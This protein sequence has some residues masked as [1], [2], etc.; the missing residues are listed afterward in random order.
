MKI[1]IAPNAF[2][3]SLSASSAAAIL[4][5]VARKQ[6]PDAEILA[7]PIADG[8][9]GLL[10]ALAAQGGGQWQ[11]AQVADPLGRPVEASLLWFPQRRLACIESAEAIG[12]RLLRDASPDPM[13]ASS[14][15]LGQLILAALELGAHELLI[16][17]G[18][19]ATNDGGLGLAQALGCRLLDAEGGLLAGNGQGL[20][21]FA[22]LD[23]NGLN[24]R[25]AQL[26][27]SILAD[28]ANPLLGPEGATA[29]YGPQKGVGPETQM[30][31]EAG[32][33]RLASRFFGEAL[34]NQPGVGAAGGL[35]AMLRALLG[36]ELVAGSAQVLDLL[37]FDQALAGSRL[38]LTS[39]G[40]LD[41]Q[42]LNG[43]APA[44]VAVR[45]RAVGIPCIALVGE[46]ALDEAQLRQ[47]GFTSAFSLCPGPVT[48]KTAQARAAEFL[49]A[50]A[51]QVLATVFSQVTSPTM[52]LPSSI[53][54]CIF[55]AAGYGTRF[56][57]ATKAMPKE[58]LPI[59][60]KPLIQYGVE[61]AMAAGMLDIGI[62][63]GR[64][65]RAVEDHFDISYELEHQISGTSKE[66]LLAGIRK[67][68]NDCTFS[69]TRQMEM[70]GLGHAILTA[71][72]LV[73]NEPFGVI[74]ADDLCINDQGGEGI[75]QQMLRVYEKY[76]CSVVAIEE[77]ARE[78][79]HK[80]GIIDA[81]ELDEG[82][83]KINQMVEKP[84]PE[85][86]PSTLAVIG[87]YILTPGIFDIIRRTPPGK[88]GE[89][90]I[91]DALQTQARENMV[92]AYRFQGRR[93]D[94]GSL[95]GFVEA[96]NY[97][98]QQAQESGNI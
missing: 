11:R 14:Q 78:E 69:Y 76:R 92:L 91:T 2:K 8:G 81:T 29:V 44:E 62:I 5:E 49:K 20:A 88:H 47:A 86:A 51:H 33:A 27:C 70:K 41:T 30:L 50:T 90:Q 84:S 74:L 63:T 22:A 38:V 25:L 77:V 21:S 94:C 24:P 52:P 18:G 64:S 17:L 16:G 3:G 13:R 93:F 9:D 67:I 23:T 55:P 83:F 71:E 12:L 96:T 19:S 59:L 26:K 61:E 89:L 46:L 53:K 7:L 45:A 98:Y 82:I 48:L 65:K 54:K 4:A 56:L 66:T 58:M 43:K 95:E 57:P 32:M 15:G 39:E 68:I 79:V 72:T 28:V 6:L 80:Y 73:G 40:R 10:E 85:Q 35:G 1:L 87:R 31:L 75:M 42:S 60:D 34:A 97:F 37:G 36:A